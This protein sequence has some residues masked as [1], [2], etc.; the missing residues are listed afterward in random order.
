MPPPSFRV[1][2]ASRR[3]LVLGVGNVLMGDEGVGVHAI[4]ALTRESWPAEV[5]L[6]DGGTGSFQLLSCLRDHDRVILI[7]ASM[8]GQPPGTIRVLHPKYASDFPRS[9]TAHDIG[10]RDLIETAALI[11]GLPP[12]ALVTVSIREIRPMTMTLS[13][14]VQ[15]AIPKISR[16]V[17][18]LLAARGEEVVRA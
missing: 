12:I 18:R 5:T 11:Q 4:E 7:D 17:R 10:L 15:A 13:D 1:A 8:D 6:L 9:L 14:A 2:S 16:C 3:V